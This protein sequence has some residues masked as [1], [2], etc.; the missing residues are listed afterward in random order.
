MSE[1]AAQNQGRVGWDAGLDLSEL[2]A[3]FALLAETGMVFEAEPGGAAARPAKASF[4]SLHMSRSRGKPF[5]HDGATN[6]SIFL[7]E[8]SAWCFGCAWAAPPVSR[9]KEARREG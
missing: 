1:D 9:E 6:A 8:A 7:D 2:G 3:A 5:V 4:L